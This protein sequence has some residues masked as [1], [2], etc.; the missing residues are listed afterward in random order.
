MTAIYLPKHDLTFVHIPKNAGTAI[1]K[2]FRENKTFFLADPI[3]F[4]HH[5][6]LP[7]LKKTFP[8]NKTF[9]IVRNPWDRLVSFYT[10]ARDG[11]TAWCVN[12]RK[13]NNLVDEFPSFNQW[14]NNLEKYET[15]HWFKTTTNQVDWIPDGVTHLLRQENLNEDF[16]KIQE[17]V[18]FHIDLDIVNRTFHDTYRDCFNDHQKQKV[19]KLFEKDIDTFGYTF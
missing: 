3:F 1:V 17:I 8:T 14:L 9:A 18:D 16:K 4:G 13:A 12:F 2:W 7:M 10:F 11:Q 19:A 15:L 6:S 5:E